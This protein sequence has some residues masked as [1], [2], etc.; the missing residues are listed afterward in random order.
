MT[1]VSQS[2]ES[3]IN[4]NGYGFAGDFYSGWSQNFAAGYTNNGMVLG[5]GI[6]NGSEAQYYYADAYFPNW[7]FGLELRRLANDVTA[8]YIPPLA[9][10]EAQ[11]DVELRATLKVDYLWNQWTLSGEISPAMELNRY[12]L[13]DHQTPSFRFVLGTVYHF[14]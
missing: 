12:Q 4:N 2:K 5:A 3:L 9:A 14:Q 7:H 1:I 13:A 11:N 6:G 10:R 8:L